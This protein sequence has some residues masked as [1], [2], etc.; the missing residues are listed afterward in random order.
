M[1]NRSIYAYI[2]VVLKKKWEKKKI[3]EFQK[4]DIHNIQYHDEK[5]KFPYFFFFFFFF[6]LMSYRKHILRTQKHDR[7][8]YGTRAIR[9]FELLRFDCT[10]EPQ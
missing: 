2:V 5:R 10:V 8:S 7:I 6:F 1:S 3:V 9:V 4:M